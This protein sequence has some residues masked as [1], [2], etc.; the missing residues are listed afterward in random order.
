MNPV[1]RFAAAWVFAL[2]AACAPTGRL[3]AT[4]PPA[5]AAGPKAPLLFPGEEKFLAN[6]RQ[7]T[8]GGQNAEAY[9]SADGRQIIFQ[10]ND[11]GR[12]P[13]DQIFVMN[14]DG[15]GKRMV[16]NGKGKTTCSYFF[17]S[18]DRI[19]YGS[20]FR[21][22]DACPPPPDRSRGYVWALDDYDIYTAKPDGG[23]IRPLFSSPAYD[24]EATVSRDGRKIVFTSARDGDLEVYSMNADG[25]GVARLTHTAGYDGGPFYSYD[26]KRIV[27]RADHPKTPEDLAL[28]REN[29]AHGTYAPKG[30]EI[31]VMNADGSED[32]AVTANGAANFAPYFF[33]G[34]NRIIFSSNVGDPKGRDFELYAI[35]AD[36]TGLTRVTFSPEFDGFPMF[37][38]D[39]S[40]LVFASNRNGKRPRETNIFVADWVETPAR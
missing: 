35:N 40:K 38:S 6:V 11:E 10:S 31:R 4:A 27:Y 39:G 21:I 23:D 34:G 16:S 37:N 32:R 25:S 33:P 5:P 24:A 15:S 1:S 19:L 7:L 12:L 18:G 14:A 13:C 20:T 2:T 30:L 22:G 29:L 9:W 17:P 28:Y 36:G 3:P 8:F 26:G